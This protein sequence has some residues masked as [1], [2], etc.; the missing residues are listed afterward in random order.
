MIQGNKLGN[1]TEGTEEN[2][3]QREQTSTIP[4]TFI[5]GGKN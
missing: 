2:P 1:S 4:I 5:V 3:K